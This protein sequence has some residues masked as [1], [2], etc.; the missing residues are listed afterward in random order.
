[1]SNPFSLILK[2]S[3]PYHTPVHNVYEQKKTLFLFYFLRGSWVL[4][5]LFS[6]LQL[7]LF[8]S[9]ANFMAV[10]CVIFAW[11]LIS[12]SFLRAGII[13]NFPISSFLVLAF[14]LTQFYLPLVFTLLEGKAIV[15]N[16][17]LPYEVFLHSTLCLI[18]LTSSHLFYRWIRRK[19][20][21]RLQS[22]L[23]QSSFFHTPT[24][25]QLWIMGF[26]GLLS[27][28]Y[29]HFYAPSVG[30]EVSGFLDKSIQGL[31]PFTYS[32]FFILVGK[33]YG[34]KETVSRNQI[35]SLLIFTALLFVVSIG[36]NSR[37][38]FIFGFTSI[39]FSYILGLL[40]GMFKPNFFTV[41]N[42]VI[43]FCAYFLLSGPIADISTAMVLVRG[44]RNDMSRSEL[45]AMTLEA[46]NDKKAIAQYRSSSI[47]AKND[48]DENYM[49]NIFLARF[50]NI[51]YND[52]SLIQANKLGNNNSAMFQFSVDKAWAT[53]P[54]P[55]LSGLGIEVDKAEINSASF[56]DFLYHKAGADAN[57]LGTYRTGHFAG[58][59][60]AAFGWWY[61]LI[62][63]VFIFPIFLLFDLFF[64]KKISYSYSN[65]QTNQHIVKFSLCG[66][67]SMTVIFQ[68]LPS[69]SVV[70]LI[71]F[72]VRG[73]FQIIFL[74]YIMYKFSNFFNVKT[75]LKI[76]I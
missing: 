55:I 42:I 46:F 29:I 61:L 71:S 58:T 39:G 28:F 75:R 73:W 41:K 6:T 11:V 62:L 12:K 52:A 45:V 5:L 32:P 17:E 2:V 15:Y 74:Y 76:T 59:G 24:N 13:N 9:I 8:W 68:F 33:L 49:D 31:I 56:G 60:M 7:I 21:N 23:K 20:N 38:S 69:E 37:G 63:G 47:A 36:R 40:L 43:I 16:L 50:C 22:L 54:E 14:T 70:S 66:L 10:F 19:K 65:L 72:L 51:K 25:R 34:N 67:L 4:L 1:M 30:R 35:T 48:W 44:Q 53:L 64:I 57:A 18:V 27:M 3:N 26:L